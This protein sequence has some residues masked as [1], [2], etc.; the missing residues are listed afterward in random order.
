MDGATGNDTLIWISLACS[1]ICQFTVLVILVTETA[2][3]FWRKAAGRSRCCSCPDSI[4]SVNGNRN[5]PMK[6]GLFFA[7]IFLTP[8]SNRQWSCRS[9]PA[10]P[11]RLPSVL[12]G[13][14]SPPW[15]LPALPAGERP[16]PPG[17]TS[18]WA[19]SPAYS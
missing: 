17:T 8:P 16:A 1:R 7:F 10:S 18:A 11:E 13:P 12:S 2:A 5:R 4:F 3:P 9:G 19:A 14:S 6:I 15:L